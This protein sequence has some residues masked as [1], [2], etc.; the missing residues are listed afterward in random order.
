[1]LDAGIVHNICHKTIRN[2]LCLISRQKL[3]SV[4]INCK[5]LL[6]LLCV[7]VGSYAQCLCYVC[8]RIDNELLFKNHNSFFR[9]SHILFSFLVFLLRLLFRVGLGIHTTYIIRSTYIR[10][11]Y[12][13]YRCG[14]LAVCFCVFT[15]ALSV[16]TQTMAKIRSNYVYLR[17]FR[18]WE[19]GEKKEVVL[20]LFH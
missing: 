20:L 6:L 3:I 11:T 19:R 15:Y 2:S 18:I 1:M 12:R 9:F 14:M 4:L 5:T 8:R 7:L 16:S 17:F 10:D 13:V